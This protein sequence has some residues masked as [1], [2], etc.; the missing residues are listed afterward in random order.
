VPIAIGTAGSVKPLEW[1]GSS[2]DDL[3]AFPKGVRRLMGQ[4][5]FEAQ[6]GV[7]HPDAKPMRGFGGAGVLE[8]VEN[9]DGDTWRAVNTVQFAGTV[10]VLHAF[11]KKSKRGVATP[12][13]DLDLIR[14]RLKV[15]R[16]RHAGAMGRKP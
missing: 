12:K 5:L 7:K 14:A 4:A 2:Q 11:Q 3:Q 8:V 13:R 6:R 1:V 16:D 9:H 10:Y 15:A